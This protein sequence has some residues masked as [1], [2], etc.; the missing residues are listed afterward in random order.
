MSSQNK[1]A[2]IEF[3]DRFEDGPGYDVFGEEGYKKIVSVMRKN[4]PLSKGVIFDMGCG[5]GAFT[6]YISNAYPKCNVTGMDISA[7]SIRKAKNDYPK[8]KFVR[9]DV[10]NTG[11]KSHT[12][13]MVCYTGIFHHFTDFGKVAKEA[14]R[15]LKPGG[16]VF[17][18]DPN[19]YNPAFWLYRSKKSPFYSPVGITANERLLK[20]KEVVDVFSKYGIAMK[21]KIISGIK[22]TYVESEAAKKLLK[23]YNFFDKILASTVLASY[24]GSFILGFGVK[25]ASNGK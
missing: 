5:T 25:E 9:G 3:F 15:I 22:F 14:S 1:R 20:S 12:V 24:V 6:Q 19:F 23:I 7:G 13:D 2:E 18:Y 10:E 11:I 8:I 16:Y 21:P 17:S 4:L